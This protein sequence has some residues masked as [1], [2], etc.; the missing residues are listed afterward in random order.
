MKFDNEKNISRFFNLTEI[1]ET[2]SI[3]EL[4]NEAFL[5]KLVGDVITFS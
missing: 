2:V 1:N 5:V 3:L 4:I